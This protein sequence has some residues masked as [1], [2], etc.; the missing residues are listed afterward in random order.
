M[1]TEKITMLIGEGASALVINIQGNLGT[2]TDLANIENV[3]FLVTKADEETLSKTLR[4]LTPNSAL[5]ESGSFKQLEFREKVGKRIRSA[6]VPTA[7]IPTIRSAIENA[8]GFTVDG[9]VCGA[10]STGLK[11]KRR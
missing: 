8:N 7:S 4:V 2:Y 1:G 9:V 11:R 5:L 3:G 10:V 6:L